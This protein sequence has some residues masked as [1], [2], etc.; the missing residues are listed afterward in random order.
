[1]KLTGR[2]TADFASPASVAATTA[3]LWVHCEVDAHATTSLR[4]PRLDAG[5]LAVLARAA[6]SSLEVAVHA[7]RAACLCTGLPAEASPV[8][9]LRRSPSA[10]KLT[11]ATAANFASSARVATRAA[12][13]TV[14]CEIY[15]DTAAEF[16]SRSNP[17]GT[18]PIQTDASDPRNAIAIQAC[19]SARVRINLPVDAFSV[20]DFPASFTN[21]PRTSSSTLDVDSRAT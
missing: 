2:I 4:D 19:R 20:A 8:A 3:I 9:E 16:R 10:L 13:L 21:S 5:T 18:G 15:A 11:N 12:V 6:D 7:V 1:M 14:N 17:A